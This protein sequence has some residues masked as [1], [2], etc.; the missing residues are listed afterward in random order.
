RKRQVRK[1][2]KGITLCMPMPFKRA[3][4]ADS[5]EEEATESETSQTC[6]A[7]RF[8][9]YW[10]VLTQTEGEEAHVPPIP[11]F[12]IDSALR[13][14]NVTRTP[15][16]EMNGDIQGFASGRELAVGPVEAIQHKPTSHVPLLRDL[17]HT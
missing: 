7:F 9:A 17:G 5:V 8:R 10:F 16:D 11:G 3:A 1:G 15:F 12:D 13:V 2:E 14:L 6:Y 4:Q